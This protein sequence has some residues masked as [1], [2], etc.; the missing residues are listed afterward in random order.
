MLKNKFRMMTRNEWVD[1]QRQ[2]GPKG[3]LQKDYRMLTGMIGHTGTK[4]HR[5]QTELITI[6]DEKVIYDCYSLC[7]SQRMSSSSRI[8]ETEIEVNC[9][10]CGTVEVK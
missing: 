4:I 6:N 1:L 3:Q 8:V 10:R 2:L 5:L 7:G 9:K